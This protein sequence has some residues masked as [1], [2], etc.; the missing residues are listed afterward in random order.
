[1][2]CSKT[3]HNITKHPLSLEE[4]RRLDRQAGDFG[5]TS[6]PWTVRALKGSTYIPEGSDDDPY[7]D[8]RTKSRTSDIERRWDG[9]TFPERLAG[10]LGIVTFSDGSDLVLSPD[11]EVG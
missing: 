8:P 10:Q 9:A 11:Q 7:A 4:D 5:L 1:M 2:T 3:E 6:I